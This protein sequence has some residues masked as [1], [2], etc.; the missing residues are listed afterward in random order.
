MSADKIRVIKK[1]PGEFLLVSSGSLLDVADIGF[2]H[3]PLIPPLFDIVGSD[4]C[5]KLNTLPSPLFLPIHNPAI[6]LFDKFL[7][8]RGSVGDFPFGIDKTLIKDFI[9]HFGFYGV[10]GFGWLA[11]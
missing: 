5:H 2:C 9:E 8:F 6:Q 10:W 7:K 4:D 11:A 1:C 3:F